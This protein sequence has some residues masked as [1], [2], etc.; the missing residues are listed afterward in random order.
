[1]TMPWTDAGFAPVDRD[2]PWDT[3][4]GEGLPEQDGAVRTLSER[5]RSI[6]AGLLLG[7]A[8]FCFLTVIAAVLGDVTRRRVAAILLASGAVAAGSYW[9]DRL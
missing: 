9:Y 7:M 1:M 5:D 2:G 4:T 3:E 6:I 8:A